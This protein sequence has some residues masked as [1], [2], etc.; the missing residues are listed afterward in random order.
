MTTTIADALKDGGLSADGNA[1]V[2]FTP[3]AVRDASNSSAIIGRKTLSATVNPTTGAFTIDLDPGVWD[4]RIKTGPP[5]EKPVE[6]TILVPDT[7]DTLRLWPLIEAYVPPANA[8]VY[9]STLSAASDAAVAVFV[10]GSGPTADALNATYGRKDWVDLR[11][12]TG[13]DQTG[14]NSVQSIFDQAVAQAP[15]GA[16]ILIPNGTY[17]LENEWVINKNVSVEGTAS[18]G[19]YYALTEDF[20]FDRPDKFPHLLGVTL[21]Q[22]T[23]GKDIIR[24][25]KAASTVHLK[26]LGLRFA[27][28]IRFVNTGH[29]VN[30]TPSTTYT[31][32]AGT[33]PDHGVLDFT[34]TNI[35]VF[36]HDGNHYAAKVVNSMYSTINDLRSYGGGVLEVLTDSKY[37][38]YGNMVVNHSMGNM[39]CA[40]TAHG[41]HTKDTVAA[42]P[43][44]LGLMQFNRP[45]VNVTNQTV[46]YPTSTPP[47]SSQY[48]WLSE[49][50]VGQLQVNAP[51]LEPVAG[52]HGVNFGLGR[53]NVD[54][55][56]L[57]LPALGTPTIA[58]AA[59]AGTGAS[60]STSVANDDTGQITLTVG[61]SP[62][63]FSDLVTVTYGK[64]TD[65]GRVFISAKNSAGAQ[66]NLYIR[67]ETSTGFVIGAT[68]VPSGTLIFNYGVMDYKATAKM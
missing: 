2:R 50:S 64:R 39:F 32:G 51:D 21:L 56:G 36:G 12:W 55:S 62:T 28:A 27:N 53:H 52:V 5:G 48:R 13:L 42:G 33:Y 37:G 57:G 4:V 8:T 30:A 24:L 65:Q 19:N 20:S 6:G 22:T 66:A 59:G 60:V 41:Y 38:N 15:V 40:G 23:A 67:S 58:V 7:E 17:A 49:G 63:A 3:A 16:R 47:T 31:G 54:P 14:T 61:T 45:Q 68:N 9:G 25:P 26:N 1:T 11:D 35:R 18:M 44:A 29:G 34:W 46:R 10:E 43:G